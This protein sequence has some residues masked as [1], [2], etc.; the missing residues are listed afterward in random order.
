MFSQRFSLE[1]FAFILFF[2]SC[3]SQ[4]QPQVTKCTVQMNSVQLPKQLGK[5]LQSCTNDLQHTYAC[6]PSTCNMNN[7]I[8]FK[9]CTSVSQPHSFH[10]QTITPL[11][12]KASPHCDIIDVA[13][14]IDSRGKKVKNLRCEAQSNPS[15]QSRPSCGECYVVSSPVLITFACN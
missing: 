12:F 14:G 3:L 13:A 6:V 11:A 2:H 9:N 4:E 15:P 5:V 1:L 7:K 8:K 10:G